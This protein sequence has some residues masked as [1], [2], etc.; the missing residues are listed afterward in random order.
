M[1]FPGQDQIDPSCSCNLCS[2]LCSSYGNAR[3]PNPLCRIRDR[4]C[5]L[6]LQRSHQSRCAAA[7]TPGSLF[8]ELDP[9]GWVGS[10]G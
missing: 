6:A 5:I 8:F 2:N 3:S 1:E 9:R 10:V 7:G 4:I